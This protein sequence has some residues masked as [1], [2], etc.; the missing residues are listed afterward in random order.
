MQNN[1]TGWSQELNWVEAIKMTISLVFT[2]TEQPIQI[3][4]LKTY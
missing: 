4:V 1:F 2:N 3:S